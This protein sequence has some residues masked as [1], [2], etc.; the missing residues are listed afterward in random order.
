MRGKRMTIPSC[1]WIL[2]SDAAKGEQ[3]PRMAKFVVTSNKANKIDS[4]FD[5]S[6]LPI[7]S[8]KKCQKMTTI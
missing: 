7:K 6:K 1:F 2:R 5:Y 4:K 3:L 8:V